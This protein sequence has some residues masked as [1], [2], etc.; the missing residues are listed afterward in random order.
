[1]SLLSL[2]QF[3]SVCW[4]S[5][6]SLLRKVLF[7]SKICDNWQVRF[8]RCE[9]AREKPRMTSCTFFYFKLKVKAIEMSMYATHKSTVMPSLNA[10]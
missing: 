5:F 10:V 3:V 6:A 1:M 7:E 2:N 4:T 8:S 9:E